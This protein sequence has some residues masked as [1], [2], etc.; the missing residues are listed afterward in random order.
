M[1]GATAP[2]S[3]S[4]G[5]RILLGQLGARGD[6]LYA[7]AVARQIKVD[8]PGCHLT[9]AVGSMCRDIIEGN[10]D[11]DA[12]WEFPVAGHSEMTAAWEK[13]YAEAAAARNRGEY[14]ELFLT[15]IS[16]DNFR[17]FDGTVR[18]SIF[19]GYPGAITVPVAPV[20]RL[21]PEQ[22]AR[23]AAFVERNGLRDQKRVIL[24]EF[25]S[26]SGQ[27]FAG[28][29]FA[30][31]VSAEILARV[32]DARIVLASHLPVSATDSRI[33]DGS[34][35]SFKENAE[36]T[37][38]CAL[39]IGCSSGLS[40]LCTSDWAKP[41]PTIQL[42]RRRTSVFASFVHDHEH[43]GLPT[44]GIIEMTECPPGR[45]AA[46]VA[47]VFAAGFAQARRSFHEEIA[48]DFDHYARALFY[49]Y[50][51]SGFGAVMSSLR[52]TIGR[53]GP[54]WSLL[55]ALARCGAEYL[56]RLAGRLVGRKD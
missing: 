14:D 34:V 44:Q 23:V 27:S 46:C 31:A 29:E 7:T 45:V 41:L 35:L 47:T 49:A 8:Y 54:R 20:V 40:W 24:F 19:R 3:G 6:C 30:L 11:V 12:V 21:S 9:W 51:R 42:L 37:K 1:S 33:I 13:F 22:V 32:P 39:L 18:A 38:Y 5:K 56:R 36:L 48:L 52:H 16:P 10:P 53:Y 25:A 2:V 26:M 43:F 50:R 4:S 15:Q 17:N 28:P 55:H